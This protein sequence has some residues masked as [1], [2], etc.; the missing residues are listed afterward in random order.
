MPK[1]KKGKQKSS[2]PTLIGF[3]LIFLGIFVI[4]NLADIELSKYKNE[5]AISSRTGK[6]PIKINNFLVD[7]LEIFDP[8]QRIV[9]PKHQIDLKVVEAPIID[10]FWETSEINASHGEGSA[11]P[12]QIG[13]MVIFAHARVGLFYNLRDV[14]TNDLI[15][16][17]TKDKWYQY[18][19]SKITSVYP[20]QIEVISPTADEQLTLYTCSGFADEKRL[21]VIAK[22]VK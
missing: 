6:E 9:L 14:Q 19:V 18:K 10:G 16:V 15:Y 11:S 5:K 20:N 13:N 8:P 7:P 2:L 3:L 12:G 1:R 22:P 17:F 4:S 21:I